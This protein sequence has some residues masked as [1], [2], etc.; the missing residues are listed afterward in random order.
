MCRPSQ[1]DALG[2]E[3]IGG[4]DW[5]GEGTSCMVLFCLHA[6]CASPAVCMALSKCP[7]F[8]CRAAASPRVSSALQLL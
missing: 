3:A 4:H 6:P 2:R 5:N 1:G 7:P 8:T